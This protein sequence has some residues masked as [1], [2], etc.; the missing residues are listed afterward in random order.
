MHIV[1]INF[2][3][4]GM[5]PAEFYELC[6]QLAP[7]FTEVPGLISKVWLDNPGT[8]TYGGV[9]T[10]EGVVSAKSFLGGEL[11]GQVAS[12]PHFEDLTVGDFGI[13]ESATRV[14]RGLSAEAIAP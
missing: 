13:I 12:N 8:N 1:I 2:N 14:T 7:A 6:D 9:Y 5:T 3:L 10:F 4:K 11:A